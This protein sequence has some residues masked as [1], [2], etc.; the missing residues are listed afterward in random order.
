M[1]QLQLPSDRVEE[2]L[3]AVHVAACPPPQPKPEP[4][5]EPEPQADSGLRQ[6]ASLEAMELELDFSSGEEQTETEG[7]LMAGMTEDDQRNYRQERVERYY[8]TKEWFLE[9]HLPG[10]RYSFLLY[11]RKSGCAPEWA[12]RCTLISFMAW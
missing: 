5:S 11:T 1:Q 6:E 10:C 8:R 2:F 9:V 4:E 7:E 3:A 12:V